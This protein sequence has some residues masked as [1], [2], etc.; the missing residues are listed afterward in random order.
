[1]PNFYFLDVVHF[2]AIIYF[3]GWLSSIDL[4]FIM[5]INIFYYLSYYIKSL[6]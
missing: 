6:V 3:W 4:T 2:K 1:M 5:N